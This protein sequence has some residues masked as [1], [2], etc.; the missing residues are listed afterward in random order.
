MRSG[1]APFKHVRPTAPMAQTPAMSQK[2]K[3]S[4]TS[5]DGVTP[6]M[7]ACQQGDALAVKQLL[8]R[9]V[10][11]FGTDNDHCWPSTPFNLGLTGYN[12]F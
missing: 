5:V 2:K 10:V 11:D 9:K 4:R 1:T 3:T 12:N 8:H 6:L 7:V